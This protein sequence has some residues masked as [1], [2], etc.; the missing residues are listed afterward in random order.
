[1]FK[2]VWK[3]IYNWGLSQFLL[4]GNRVFSKCRVMI[5]GYRLYVFDLI[6]LPVT[7]LA[8]VSFYGLIRHAHTLWR[9]M[10]RF[11][12]SYQRGGSFAVY[13]FHSERVK[14]G[15]DFLSWKILSR[16]LTDAR[17]WFLKRQREREV[18]LG[19]FRLSRILEV[20][21]G[22][23]W[24]LVI[25]SISKLWSFYVFFHQELQIFFCHEICSLCTNVYEIDLVI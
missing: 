3:S 19:M 2:F 25:E 14:G 7:N 12:V 20:V 22:E 9:I 24:L 10:K 4:N 5:R 16:T 13:K 23:F 11:G 6:P 1:M 21:I 18:L 8:K 17:Q 15:R